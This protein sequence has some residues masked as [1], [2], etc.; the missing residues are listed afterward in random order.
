[1][2]N[3]QTV[4][5][6]GAGTM[7]SGIAQTIAEAG[8]TVYLNDMREEFIRSG[9]EKI[10]A[11]L[12]KLTAKG[13][14]D[15]KT[16]VDISARI[17]PLREVKGDEGI[18]MVIEA[19]SEDMESKQRLFEKLGKVLSP[20]TVFSSN[21]SS[22]SIT[23]ISSKSMRPDKYI[24]LHFFN[25][26]PVMKLVELIKGAQSSNET[27]SQVR[28]FAENIGKTVVEVSE[29]PGF[30]VNRLLVPM[31]NEA[32]YALSDGV[33]CAE[34]IDNAMKLGANHP[35]GPLALGD[36]IG[37]DV[38]LAVME[39]LHKEFG[40]DKYRPCPLLRKMVLA[41]WLGRKA[42]RGFFDYSVKQAT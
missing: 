18:D 31:I 33:A 14:I 4:L 38:C 7:G 9:L 34:D 32:V 36:M 17:I 40:D 28:L 29:A 41:G 20:E 27:V 35:I 13:K 37:L 22:L 10:N 24:G 3:I 30:V 42:G 11:A 26:A 1:M 16:K 39:I 8:Y 19:I 2:K 5:V 15:E 12:A 21:T 6:I 25:P 23:G